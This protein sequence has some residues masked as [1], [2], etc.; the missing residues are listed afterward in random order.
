MAKFIIPEYVALLH[1]GLAINVIQLRGHT[2]VKIILTLI[3][4]EFS[5]FVFY[6]ESIFGMHS[7]GGIY[8][9]HDFRSK[10]IGF[11]CSQELID[12]YVPTTC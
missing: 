10:V 4:F 8:M 2:H 12:T 3:L 1:H 7:L 11:P 6:T 9:F 5:I